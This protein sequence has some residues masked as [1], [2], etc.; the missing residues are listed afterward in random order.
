LLVLVACERPDTLV[1]C[2]NANCSDNRGLVDDTMQALEASLAMIGVFDGIDVDLVWDASSETCLFAHDLD[3]PAATAPVAQ[4]RV[5]LVAYVGRSDVDRFL[6]KLGLKPHVTKDGAHHTPAQAVAHVECALELAEA[7][8]GAGRAVEII[9]SSEDPALLAVVAAHP[10]WAMREISIEITTRGSLADVPRGLRID[11]LQFYAPS[12]DPTQ[13]R[14]RQSLGTDL[15][16]WVEELTP[17]TFA[18]VRA[19]RPRFVV[20]NEAELLRRWLDR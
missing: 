18:T 10:G 16:L 6:V 13:D 1:V 4:L 3:D 8:E 15:A 14:A 11:L 9:A 20:T 17:E 5:A 19:S 7:I 2:H 12:F